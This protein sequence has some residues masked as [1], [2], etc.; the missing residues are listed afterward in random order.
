VNTVHTTG[1]N[2]ESIATIVGALIVVV[3]AI[4]TWI[5]NSIKGAVNN[6]GDR[7][8]AKLET[9]ESVSR[10]ATRVSVL[11]NEKHR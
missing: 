1:I 6:L 7:L 3:G 2:W 11:E 5:G 10:L 8:E 9:K 4:V